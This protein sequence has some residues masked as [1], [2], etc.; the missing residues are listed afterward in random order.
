MDLVSLM[1]S[2]AL[3]QPKDSRPMMNAPEEPLRS[4]QLPPDALP[5]L[6]DPPFAI[7]II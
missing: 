3:M 2:T 1:P 6:L 5:P 4:L 7:T